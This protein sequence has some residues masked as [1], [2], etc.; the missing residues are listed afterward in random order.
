MTKV[1]HS[2]LKTMR[3]YTRQTLPRATQATDLISWHRLFLKPTPTDMQTSIKGLYSCVSA[4]IK[5][6]NAQ[7][8]KN[9][10]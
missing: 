9:P 6:I 3:H 2:A 4:V 1:G 7:T 10:L 5:T 8:F